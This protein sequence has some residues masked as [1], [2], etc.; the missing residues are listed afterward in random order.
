MADK[1]L[2][3]ATQRAGMARDGTLGRDF[4]DHAW[5]AP[6]DVWL[7]EGPRGPEVVWEGRRLEA[8][9]LVGGAV[10]TRTDDRGMFD[11]FVRLADVPPDRLPRRVLAFV[12]RYGPLYLCQ[13][14]RP[15]G[16]REGPFSGPEDFL[17]FALCREPVH[18]Y[19]HYAAEA[20]AILILAAKLHM[21][22]GRSTHEDEVALINAARA[23]RGM[24]PF[25]PEEVERRVDDEWRRGMV[26]MSIRDWLDDADLR[27]AFQWSG[28]EPEVQPTGRGLFSVLTRHLVFAVL[29]ADGLAICY[30]CKTPYVPSRK[31]REDELH[32]CRNCSKRA[33][34]KHAQRRR[35]ARLRAERSAQET[36]RVAGGAR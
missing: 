19:R 28:K 24:A 13:H 6:L 2:A 18:T 10:E 16:H 20:K 31:P 30:E 15:L 4:A 9:E 26:A 33:S 35:R 29:R 27:M 36:D 22:E 25:M 8:G 7:E 17:C 3:I 12:K 11:A 34:D 5:L 14:G 23:R 1:Q 32:Y 21:G